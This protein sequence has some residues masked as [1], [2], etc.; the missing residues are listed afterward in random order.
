MMRITVCFHGK[1]VKGLNLCEI[2]REIDALFIKG[3]VNANILCMETNPF[4]QLIHEL[5]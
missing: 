1:K 5:Y 4:L 3:L 2:E